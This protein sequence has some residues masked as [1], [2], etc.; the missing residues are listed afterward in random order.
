MQEKEEQYAPFHR[1]LRHWTFVAGD[2]ETKHPRNA[3]EV[4]NR[5]VEELM[6]NVGKNGSTY[7]ALEHAY[8]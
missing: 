5:K 8:K 1:T 6:Y 2:G 7:A 3:D 4:T